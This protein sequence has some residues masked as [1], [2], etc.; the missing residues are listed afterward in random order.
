MPSNGSQPANRE[1]N[2]PG[3]R[4]FTA[5]SRKRL[6]N[7]KTRR[8]A[9][10]LNGP[11]V[12]GNLSRSTTSMNKRHDPKSRGLF[13]T[14]MKN[15]LVARPFVCLETILFSISALGRLEHRVL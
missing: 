4:K 11:K 14:F 10:S 5:H 12:G 13:R 2:R 1:K 8:F 15:K 6:T 3:G 9:S 7:G